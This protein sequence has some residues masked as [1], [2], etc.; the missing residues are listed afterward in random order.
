M[1][2]NRFYSGDNQCMKLIW[3]SFRGFE[4]VAVVAAVKEFE[5]DQRGEDNP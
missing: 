5:Q 2:H 1:E 3:R 4:V